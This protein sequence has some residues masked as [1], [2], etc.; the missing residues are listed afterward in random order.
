MHS[1]IVTIH[2]PEFV[3]WLGTFNKIYQ[4]DTYIIMDDV[5]FTKRRFVNRNKIRANLN[6]GW[7][8]ITIPILTKGRFDQNI[9]D[10]RIKSD[11]RWREPILKSIVMSYKKAPYFEDVYYLVEKCLSIYHEMIADINICLIKSIME[12]LDIHKTIFIQSEIGKI[13][14]TGSELVLE[15][16]KR[17]DGTTYLSGQ[18]GKDYLKE[19]H[20]K[21]NNIKVLYQKFIHPYYNQLHKGFIEG[22]SIL[23]LLFNH[24][25]NS[26]EFI[27]AINMV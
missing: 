19:E 24:G 10:V 7:I 17:V 4:C 2:Q 16:V 15:L 1:G 23:D 9:K 26:I 6:E 12:Y 8:W 3:P 18:S 21:E 27:N 13:D 25:K 11:E 20:F 5:Q 14:A 22:M